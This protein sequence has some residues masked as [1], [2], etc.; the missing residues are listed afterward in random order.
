MVMVSSILHLI[1]NSTKD[2]ATLMS[3][4]NRGVTG[5][6]DLDHFAT[7]GLVAVDA[8]D[9]SL[10]FS[11]AAHQPLLVYRRDS[12]AVETVD[13]KSIPLGVERTTAYAG[14][15][16]RLGPGDVL[17]MHTDGLVEAMNDQ[18]KQFGRKNLAQAVHRFHE[19]P[20]KEMAE[21]IIGEVQDFSGHSRQHDDQTILIMKAKL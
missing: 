10:E 5:Q 20:A 13:I 18:G 15:K 8:A 7:L 9:N 3:W 19:L 14:K 17:V 16:V 11:N 2:M 6:V 1:T 12:D 21:A 4:V